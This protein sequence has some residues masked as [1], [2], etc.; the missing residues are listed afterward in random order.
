[1]KPFETKELTFRVTP[2]SCGFFLIEGL[3]WNIQKLKARFDFH[4]ELGYSFPFEV[5]PLKAK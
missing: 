5:Q 4:N 3:V 2:R 1:M